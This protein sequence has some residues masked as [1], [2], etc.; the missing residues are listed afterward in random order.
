MRINYI[1]T[2]YKRKQNVNAYWTHPFQFRWNFFFFFFFALYSVYSLKKAGKMRIR[3]R[4]W[5]FSL[6]IFVCDLSKGREKQ[7]EKW[8]PVRVFALIVGSVYYIYF[9]FF[10]LTHYFIICLFNIL[11]S[12]ETNTNTIQK[13]RKS[14]VI[15]QLIKFSFHFFASTFILFN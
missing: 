6:F 4:V 3:A 11:G 1:F 12:P 15:I 8:I 14:H 2:E 5:Q 10:Q 13:M 9:F 7:N